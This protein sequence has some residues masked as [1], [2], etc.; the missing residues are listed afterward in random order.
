VGRIVL[1]GG[2]GVGLALLVVVAARRGRLSMRYTLGWL[3]VATCLVL[4]GVFGSFVD[5]IAEALGV[6][7][8][9]VMLTSILTCFLAITVQLSISVSGL[10]EAVRTLAEANAILEE[11]IRSNELTGSLVTDAQEGSP[12]I[13]EGP[14]QRH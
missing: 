14:Q 11:R 7:S 2:A 12:Q 6:D 8:V 9:T 13:D 10:T 3:F 1:V 4:G 5:V